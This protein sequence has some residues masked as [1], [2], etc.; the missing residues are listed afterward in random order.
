MTKEPIEVIF[1][2]KKE[3]KQPTPAQ[4]EPKQ[5]PAQTPVTVIVTDGGST[6][7]ISQPTSSSNGS[8]AI[9]NVTTTN[10]A[11][12]DPDYERVRN[13]PDT[14]SETNRIFYAVAAGLVVIGIVI[15][16]VVAI[17]NKKKDNENK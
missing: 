17:V 9:K 2:Y 15:I 12:V 8:V 6:S 1:W 16:A 10:T 3:A 11:K 13:V 14:D 7:T 4:N 5:Q